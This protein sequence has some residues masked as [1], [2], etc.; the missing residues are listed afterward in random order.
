MLRDALKDIGTDFPRL[1]AIVADRGYRGLANFITQQKHLNLDIKAPP[2]GTVGFT[3]IGPPWRVEHAFAQLG[4]WRRLARCYEG[5]EASA[6]AWLG[7]A[8]VGYLLGRTTL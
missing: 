6:K 2:P 4:R 7:V 8:S 1:Q 3:P 5:S